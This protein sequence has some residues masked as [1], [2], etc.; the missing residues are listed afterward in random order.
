MHC[1][2]AHIVR[3]GSTPIQPRYNCF[4]LR[5]HIS[6]GLHRTASRKSV[7][8]FV[9]LVFTG[10]MIVRCSPKASEKKDEGLSPER[11]PQEEL[12]T[13]QI[14]EGLK[15]QLVAQEPMVQD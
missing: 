8:I 2:S 5:L 3:P 7:S 11:S 9:A 6:A 1:C 4:V 12:A 15:V 13:F 10:L 14:P